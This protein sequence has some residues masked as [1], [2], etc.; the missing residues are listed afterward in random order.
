[1]TRNERTDRL[2]T[3]Q[4]VERKEEDGSL[5]EERSIVEEQN[6]EV[7][8]IV[9]TDEEWLKCP[10]NPWNWPKVKKWMVMSSVGLFGFLASVPFFIFIPCLRFV[11]CLNLAWIADIGDVDHLLARCWHPLCLR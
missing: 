8:T 2:D 3:D 9:L 4:M 6:V 1:M 5:E 7:E 10:E 11:L